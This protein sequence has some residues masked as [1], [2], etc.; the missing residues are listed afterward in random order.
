M[1]YS[2]SAWITEIRT[3]LLISDFTFKPSAPNCKSAFLILKI[4]QYLANPDGDISF[5]LGIHERIDV[6][7]SF[8]QGTH[9]R[10]DIRIDISIFIRPMTTKT[11]TPYLDYY[12]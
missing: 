6:G 9:V 4:A 10:I 7:I 2:N 3:S 11:S 12:I 5:F 8:F 1:S